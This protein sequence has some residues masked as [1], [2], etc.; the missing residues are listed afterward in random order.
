MIDHLSYSADGKSLAVALGRGSGIR[1]YRSSNYAEAGRDSDYGDDC[2]WAEFDRAG[3]LVTASFDGFVRLYDE[4]LR[5]I[6]KKKA[7]GGKSPFSARFSPDGSK[8]AVG[9]EDTTA[10]N[11]LSGDDLSFLSAPQTPTS[12]LDLQSVAWS[13]DGRAL[14]AGGVSS[15]LSQMNEILSWV[16]NGKPAY[17]PAS[18]STIMDI[19]TLSDGR[20]A[21]G[22]ADPAAGML[23]QSG[24]AVW[25]HAPEILDYNLVR[26]VLG[27]SPD[28]ST[29]EFGFFSHSLQQGFQRRAGRFELA[30]RQ[31]SLDVSPDPTLRAPRTTGVDIKDW[32]DS[33]A[34]P[35]LNGRALPLDQYEV[36]RSLAV[37]AKGD[38]FLLGSDRYIRLFEARG[39]LRWRTPTPEVAWAVNLTTDGR[40]AVAALGDGTIRWYRID[41]GQEVMGLFVDPDGKRWVLWTPEGFY[42]SSK[43]ADELIGYHLNHGPDHEGEFVRVEQLKILFY[44]PDILSQRLKPEG[45]KLVRDELARIGDVSAILRSASPPEL[46]LLSP[47]ETNSDGQFTLRFHVADRGTGV[48]SVVYRIDGVEIDGRDLGPTPGKDTVERVFDLPDGRHTLTATVFDGS[49]RLESRSI[50]TVVNVKQR[51]QQAA[52]YVVAVGISHYRDTSLNQGVTFAASDAATIA[53]RLKQQGTGLFR[54]VVASVLTDANASL[55]NIQKTVSEMAARIQ[56]ADEFVLYLAGHGKAING[57]YTFVPWNAIYSNLKALHDQSLNEERLQALLKTIRATKTL[58]LLD[59]CSAGAALNGRELGEKGSIERLASLTGRGILAA[60]KSD[61][62]ALEGVEGHGVFTY[63]VLDSLTNAFDSDGLIQVGL[64]ADRVEKM[65]PEITLKRFQY[66]QFPMRLIEGQTF[67]IARK[68]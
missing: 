66:E 38:S 41:N 37:S 14:F 42:D 50:S 53:A 18:T 65:V 46:S 55:D 11:I 30:R 34:R 19:R 27:L 52:L 43:D 16:G 21:F 24:Q 31:I 23:D 56:P 51:K 49:N 45:D 33:S 63:A 48:G 28:G 9:F 61:Q 36:S 35:T 68:Q 5:L 47:P 12:E 29:V 2:Y 10:V 17:W 44:R 58:L 22:A 4:N 57:E 26:R 59:T 54:E 6:A 13:R 7:P 40:Y 62:V 25:Q 3:R 20:I 60:T 15:G 64:L 8:I 1:V 32:W 67:P 39:S